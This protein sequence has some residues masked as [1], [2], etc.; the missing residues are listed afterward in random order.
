[1]LLLAALSPLPAEDDPFTNPADEETRPER[2]ILK[3]PKAMTYRKIDA[4]KHEYAI[5]GI[6]SASEKNVALKDV[7]LKWSRETEPESLL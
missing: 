6:Y 2:T 3:L 1:M 4:T 5:S 7:E